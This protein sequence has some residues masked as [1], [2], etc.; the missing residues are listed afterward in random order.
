MR[1]FRYDFYSYFLSHCMIV[2][3]IVVV[4]CMFYFYDFGNYFYD[5]YFCGHDENPRTYSPVGG[6]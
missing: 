4:L 5:F 6:G 3:L 2:F 1:L